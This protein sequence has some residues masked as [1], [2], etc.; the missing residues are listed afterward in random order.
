MYHV[1]SNDRAVPEAKRI[2][3]WQA[4]AWASATYALRIAGVTPTELQ[5]LTTIFAYQARLVTRSFSRVTHESNFDFLA[6][7]QLTLPREQLQAR[8]LSFQQRQLY[9]DAA[10]ESVVN[11][12]LWRNQ[13]VLSALE[14][15]P[16][17]EVNFEEKENIIC[18]RCGQEFNGTGPLRWRIRRSH[19]EDAAP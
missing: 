7:K 18:A 14:S 3:I 15:L 12:Y 11:S 4:T 1:I 8:S 6:R 13:A 19:E 2:Q 9:K 16:S 17:H 5:R 10:E